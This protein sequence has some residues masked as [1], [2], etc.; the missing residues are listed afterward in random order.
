MLVPNLPE[1][2]AGLYSRIFFKVSPILQMG[3]A[4]KKS[5]R[6]LYLLLKWTLNI[7]LLIMLVTVLTAITSVVLGLINTLILDGG[8]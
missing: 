3:K 8:Q 4:L 1:D 2:K 6:L 5:N 7:V